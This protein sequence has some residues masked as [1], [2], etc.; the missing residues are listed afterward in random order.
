MIGTAVSLV[1]QL[2]AILAWPVRWWDIGAALSSGILW[3]ENCVSLVK[4]SFSLILLLRWAVPDISS[5][6]MILGFGYHWCLRLRSTGL[7]VSFMGLGSSI[8]L[9]VVVLSQ[10]ITDKLIEGDTLTIAHRLH[11]FRG[12]P[13]LETS[14]LLSISINKLR[15]ISHQVIKCLEVFIKTLVTLSQLHE[16]GVLD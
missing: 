1:T 12:K 10:G 16:L 8:Y 15:S 5:R 4:T 9:I 13:P 14:Y 6:W 11:Q 3:Q 2:V 7:K